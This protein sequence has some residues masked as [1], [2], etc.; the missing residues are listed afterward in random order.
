MSESDGNSPKPLE[1]EPRNAVSTAN[2][3]D[4]DGSTAN[5]SSSNKPTTNEQDSDGSTANK[6]PTNESSDVESPERKVPDEPATPHHA[7]P[8]RFWLWFVLTLIAVIYVAN[9]VATVSISGLMKEHPTVLILLNPITRNLLLVAD[10]IDWVAFFVIATVRRMVPHPAWFMIGRWYGKRGIDWVGKKSPDIGQYITSIEKH[11]P[12]FGWLIV[13]LYPHPL[14]CAMAGASKMK[15]WTFFWWCAAGIVF[16]VGIAFAFGDVLT[17]V[18]HPI[19]NFADRWKWWIIPGT[20]ALMALSYFLN[21]Q[22]QKWESV[23]HMERDLEAENS[24]E[25]PLKSSED[26]NTPKSD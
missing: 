9:W 26:P 8:P 18:T 11:F 2:L 21:D 7:R 6:S 19:V 3:L 4:S 24:S 14:I 12:R 16:W 17:P 23:G 13:A 15:F 1:E 25:K 5:S 22:A 10:R 20:F